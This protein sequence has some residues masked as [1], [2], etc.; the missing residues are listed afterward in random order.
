MKV[1]ELSLHGLKLIEPTV[2]EDARGF[3]LE[4]YN[5]R[6]YRGSGIDSLFVQENHSSSRRRVLRGIHYQ[7]SPGQDKLVRVVRGRVFDVA[8]DLRPKSKTFG[9]WHGVYLDAER[10][11]QLFVP[12]GFGHGFCVLSDRA[13]VLY[14]LSSF[15][16]PQA[17]QTIKWDDPDLAVD[18]PIA[19]PLVS[20]RDN[21]GEPFAEYRRRVL[22]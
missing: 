5:Q 1:T 4:S 3:L 15:Y 22:G 20:D 8:V 16:D 12:L 14:K 19:D 7:S 2:F 6:R 9:K 13:D 21:G 10:H 11:Q 17:E 18:W